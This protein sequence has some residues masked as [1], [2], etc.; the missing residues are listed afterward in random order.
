MSVEEKIA[1]VRTYREDRYEQLVDAVYA[2]RGW[3]QNGIPTLE[4][5]Q[6]LGLDT[7]PELVELVKNKSIK[8]A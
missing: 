2:R 6:R 1:A 3:D 5:L 4:T 8:A 7:L